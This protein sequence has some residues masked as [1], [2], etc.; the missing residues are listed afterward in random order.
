VGSS[1]HDRGDESSRRLRST[2]ATDSS[3]DATS[4]NLITKATAAGSEQQYEQIRFTP[5]A[6]LDGLSHGGRWEGRTVGGI[7]HKVYRRAFKA[8]HLK[9]AIKASNKWV[10]ILPGD[11]NERSKPADSDIIPCSST[12]IRTMPLVVFGSLGRDVAPQVLSRQGRKD[13]CV[14]S[15]AESGVLFMGYTKEARA[16]HECIDDSLTHQDPMTLLTQIVKSKKVPGL[17]VDRVFK[18]GQDDMI[19]LLKYDG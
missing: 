6:N 19:D 9:W 2:S 5:P 15:S 14:F 3:P 12:A 7:V 4:A 11:V 16:I 10:K 17:T 18:R 13:S 1:T 8:K